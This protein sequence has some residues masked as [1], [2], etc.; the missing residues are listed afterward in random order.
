[1]NIAMKKEALEK[2]HLPF[3]NCIAKYANPIKHGFKRLKPTSH[4][5]LVEVD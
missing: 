3:R 4:M 1:M 5:G 2:K